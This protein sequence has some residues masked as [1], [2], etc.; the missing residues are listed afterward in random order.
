MIVD[1]FLKLVL[2][3]AV[4]KLANPV[5]GQ[6]KTFKSAEQTKTLVIFLR[7]KWICGS[8]GSILENHP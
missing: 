7:S 1:M 2:F 5:C 3:G 8:G 4:H 6:T